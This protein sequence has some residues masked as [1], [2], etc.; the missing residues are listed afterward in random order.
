MAITYIPTLR[1]FG[2]GMVRGITFPL[3]GILY[4]AMTVSS[5]I[6]YLSGRREWRGVRLKK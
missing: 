2:L 4:A 3:A 6:N 1:F 5:A